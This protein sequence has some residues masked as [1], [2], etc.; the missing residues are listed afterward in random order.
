MTG[1]A[2]KLII[3]KFSFET[4]YPMPDNIGACQAAVLFGEWGSI[5]I[6][7]VLNS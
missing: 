3:Q 5:F 1:V 2:F 7:R 6:N 4:P